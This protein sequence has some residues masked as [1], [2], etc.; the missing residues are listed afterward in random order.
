MRRELAEW[1]QQAHDLSRRHAAGLIPVNRAT[2]R[3]EH[4]RDLQDAL[5]VRL[6]ELAGSRVRYGYRR[7]TVMLKREGWEV[8]AKRIYR[9]YTEEGL[10]VRTKRRKERAQRQRIAQGPASRA[11]ERWSMDF[12]AQRLADGRWIRVLTVVDQYTRECLTLHADMALSGEKVATALDKVVALRGAPKSIT[13][14]NGTEFASKA[15]DHWAYLNG[16]HLDFIRP[17]RPVEN[18]YIESFN[19]R[20]R[21]ECLNVEV[22]FSPADARRKL[23]IWFDDYNHH[24]PHSALADRTPAEFAA[25]CSCGIDIGRRS[26]AFPVTPPCVRVRTRRFGRIRRPVCSARQEVPS[27]RSKRRAWH[28]KG[29]LCG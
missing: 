27:D 18:G 24:R 5:R 20:L 23:A 16:V 28:K 3:Y 2:L 14:D 21:D 12:V 4:H 7:L 19:G 6:R 25:L 22:F 1:A 9:L 11:N 8:N 29:L 13:V 15:M 10:I 17:G 26:L